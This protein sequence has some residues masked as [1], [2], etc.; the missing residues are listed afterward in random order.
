MEG[1][2]TDTAKL[3]KNFKK[4][5]GAVDMMKNLEVS[6]SH[7]LKIEIAIQQVAVMVER[8]F[9]VLSSLMDGKLNVPMVSAAVA[10][11]EFT[12]IKEAAFSQGLEA[13]FQDFTLLYQLPGSYVA[14]G[15]Q[16]S[17]VVDVPLIPTT[18]Y[19]KFTLFHHN[20]LPFFLN[21]RLVRLSGESNLLA[22]SAHRDEF[23]EVASSALHGCLHIGTQFL[24]HH[25]G[26][27]VTLDYPCCLCSVFKAREKDAM[28]QCSLA[29]LSSHFILERVNSTSFVSF[30]NQSVS[31]IVTC[32]DKQSQAIT[33]PIQW[34]QMETIEPG[35]VLTVKNVLT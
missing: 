31:G 6:T 33:I 9:S 7:F 14:V 8:Y 29:F 16:N 23:F 11:E 20:S 12:K 3:A 34:F 21:D 26:V 2:T 30:T 10:S 18:E 32:G 13:V 35:C 28:S 19:G 27:K 1:L 17:V 22:V 15:G 24:C 5:Q 25:V 4:L